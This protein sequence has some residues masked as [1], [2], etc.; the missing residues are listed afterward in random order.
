MTETTQPVGIGQLFNG[1]RQFENFAGLQFRNRVTRMPAAA[2]PFQF[3]EGH[4]IDLPGTFQ[5]NRAE[6]SLAALLA[7]TDTSALIVL[8]DGAVRF[9]QYWLTGGRDVQWLSMSV[10]KSFVSALVGI[11]LAEGHIDSLDDPITRYASGLA[12]SAYEGVSIRD[13]LR[14][15]S[16]ARWNEDYADPQSEIYG[17][18]AALAPGGS[19]DAFMK[20]MIRETEPGSVCQYNSADTQA[21]GML[22][23]GATGGS[24]TDYMRQ[25]LYGPLGMESEGFWITDS[26]GVEMAFA[27]LLM[28]ARDFAKLGELYRNGGVWE[29]RQLVPADYVA[30]S[31]AYDSPERAPGMPLVGGH[32]FPLGYGYQWWLPEGDRGEFSAIGVYN[33]YVYVDPSRGIVIV[34]LSAN[35]RYG[36]SHDD[37]DNKDLE[38]ILAFRAVCQQFD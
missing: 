15:S 30:A 21:L 25:K 23:R 22:V 32:P 34:K 29:G 1:E 3:A 35:P 36:L 12:G 33:Q 38:N 14:M 37:A 17:L 18:G 5:L 13:V 10:A 26:Q 11:A 27:G 6:A 4:P 9:E 8:K 20:T 7:D 19:Y 28:T 24:L 31:V 2:Q 16:G